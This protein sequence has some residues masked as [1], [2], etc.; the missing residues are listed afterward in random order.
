MTK[1][2][3]NQVT[4]VGL[5][6]I[7][8]SLGMALHRGRLA[9]RVIGFSRREATIRQAKARGAIHDGDTELCPE[10]LSQSDLVIVAT[11]PETVI[12]IARKIA[13][14]TKGSLLMT[15]VA[16]VKSRIVR[17]LERTLPKRISFVGG[18]PMAGSERSGLEAADRNLF[19]GAACVVTR[20]AWTNPRAFQKVRRMWECVGGRVIVLDPKRH[21]ALAAQISHVPHL[22]AALLTLLPEK[23]ALSLAG[24]GF[25][26]STRIAASDPRVWE[27]ICGM[28]RKKILET[29]DCLLRDLKAIRS[30]IEQGNLKALRRRLQ[31][32]QFRR[33][34]LSTATDG[35]SPDRTRGR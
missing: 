2:L 9:H 1:P 23:Q 28:N 10:W 27:Q 21:D 8:G 15:D 5:G 29:L 32:A 7:G 6:L 12:P 26:D 17:E 30:F 24:G 33:N 19:K 31:S 11:P 16:S 18:H 4:I 34:R 35:L 20:T 25:S 22:T 14:M 3:F 13:A